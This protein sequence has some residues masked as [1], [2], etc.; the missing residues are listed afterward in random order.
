MQ[1]QHFKTVDEILKLAY[2]Q[3][4]SEIHVLVLK[5]KMSRLLSNIF[6]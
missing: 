2:P 3:L 4:F 1:I 6:V 5:N